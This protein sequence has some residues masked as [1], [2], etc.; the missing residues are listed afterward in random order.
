[1]T[2]VCVLS[3]FSGRYENISE[4]AE[5]KGIFKLFGDCERTRIE[6]LRDADAKALSLGGLLA[7]E[8]AVSEISSDMDGLSMQRGSSGKP[9]FS[10]RDNIAFNI[11][12]SFCLSAAA[13][14]EGEGVSIGIDIERVTEKRDIRKIS[15]RFFASKEREFLAR[16]QYSKESFFFVWTAKEALAKALGEGLASALSAKDTFVESESGRAFFARFG[17]RYGE[18]PY[19]MTLCARS[20]ESFDDIKIICD[21]DVEIYEISDRTRLYG[22]GQG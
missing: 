11:S 10:G 22:R 17:V 20:Q 19:L 4:Y 21:G 18:D 13:C 15:E 2:A 7:L 3:P 14:T 9:Y 5:A 12:H 8:R 16:T 1:M 6:K